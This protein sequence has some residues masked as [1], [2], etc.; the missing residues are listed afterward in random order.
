[1]TD[2]TLSSL[3]PEDNATD[4]DDAINMTMVFD[5]NIAD[6]GVTLELRDSVNTLVP[7]TS[8]VSA[9]TL[10]FNPTN[11]LSEGEL[12]TVTVVGTIEDLSGNTYKGQTIWSFTTEIPADTTAPSLVALTPLDGAT[13]VN[14]STNISMVFDED[15]ADTNVTLELT[16]S[17]GNV[18][19]GTDTMGTNSINFDPTN[20]LLDGEV[21]TVNVIGTIEDLSGNTY[22]GVTTWSFTA[23]DITPPTVALFTPEDGRVDVDVNTDINV[24]FDENVTNGGN[25]IDVT[26][27]TL[28]TD[29]S[30]TEGVTG[31]TL[32]FIP[33]APLE[34]D[35]NYTALIH[36][37]PT[38]DLAGNEY[39]G[40]T[41]W[42]FQ[43]APLVDNTPPEVLS[44]TPADGSTDVR[45][46]T[47]IEVTFN[48]DITNTGQI[49]RLFDNTT[50]GIITSSDGVSGNKLFL[51][52]ETTLTE[53]HNYTV[54]ILGPTKDLAGNLYT[55]Q[56]SWSFIVRPF[57]V[58]D[59]AL[60]LLDKS[61][62]RIFFSD[63]LDESGVSVDDFEIDS[64]SVNIESFDYTSIYNIFVV[65]L[66]ADQ[67]LDNG[68]IL[69]VF[70]D[71]NDTKG[72]LVNDGIPMDYSL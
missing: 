40:Q 47:D 72:N 13:D 53:E 62:V 8:S 12:Y 35:H 23:A 1:M 16:N 34:P 50:G 14:S 55:G 37:P 64:G 4:V 30:G 11:D 29:V 33:D 59:V 48:E 22:V 57:E 2:P 67:D 66:R 36:G 10:N 17:L 61:V 28:G 3:T 39:T 20:D 38:K 68:N 9:N 31:N 42:S 46:W 58:R 32:W 6:N 54:E 71:I 56:M 69:T 7:G 18:V 5:E 52:P 70:G 19:S 44:F 51:T 26:D 25:V 49:L 21:Y 45:S 60:A 24:T 43:T 63:A 41:V 27:D 15:I 65:T